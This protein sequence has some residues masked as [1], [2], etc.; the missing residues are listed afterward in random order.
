MEEITEVLAGKFLRN[1]VMKLANLQLFLES[2]VPLPSVTLVFL[3]FFLT[4][5]FII[6]CLFSEN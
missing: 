1:S 4:W 5:G 2:S 3:L 6:P